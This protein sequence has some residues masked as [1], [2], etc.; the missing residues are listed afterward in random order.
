MDM[1]ATK[2]AQRRRVSSYRRV[3]PNKPGDYCANSRLKDGETLE[4]E[5]RN[6]Q[7]FDHVNVVYKC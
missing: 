6:A 3:H 1:T 4:G 7:G 5:I 2:Q